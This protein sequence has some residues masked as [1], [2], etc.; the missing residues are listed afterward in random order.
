MYFLFAKFEIFQIVYMA[1]LLDT[2][3]GVT[4]AK[5][6]GIFNWKFLPEFINTMIRYTVYLLFGNLVDH[7]S[8]VA[9]YQID[10]IGLY[11]IAAVLIRVEAASM[12]QSIQSLPKSK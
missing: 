4:Q 11:F 6:A 7:F 2:V 3:L 8:K 10:G 5:V 12:I 1:V 9:G